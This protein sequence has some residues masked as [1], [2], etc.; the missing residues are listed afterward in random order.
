MKQFAGQVTKLERLDVLL[1]NAGIMTGVF[2]MVEEDESTVTTN[3]TSTEL[4][5]LLVSPKLK[6]MAEKFGVLAQIERRYV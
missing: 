6:E 2:K 1:E 4:L 3:V 5:A